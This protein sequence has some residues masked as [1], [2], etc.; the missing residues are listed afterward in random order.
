M[1]Y[2][3]HK[4][5]NREN[6][7]RPHTMPEP[8]DA[9]KERQP[10]TGGLRGAVS[11]VGPG[12]FRSPYSLHL[13]AA[14]PRPGRESLR[15]AERTKRR[16]RERSV[17]A[18]SLSGG[19]QHTSDAAGAQWPDIKMRAREEYREMIQALRTS[20]NDG[21]GAWSLRAPEGII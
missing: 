2:K 14:L 3:N 21:G 5:G 17:M 18:S 12:R 13:S 15:L 10:E 7:K 16:R 8:Y 11:S 4:T 19:C 6:R 9:L 20:R 1:G